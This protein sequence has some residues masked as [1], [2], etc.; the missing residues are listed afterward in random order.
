MHRSSESTP[1]GLAARAEIL[2]RNLSL[3][4]AECDVAASTLAEARRYA[5]LLKNVAGVERGRENL[6]DECRPC[7]SANGFTVAGMPDESEKQL[8][9]L[10]N[11]TEALLYR[12]DIRSGSFPFCNRAAR[13]FPALSGDVPSINTPCTGTHNEKIIDIITKDIHPEDVEDIRRLVQTALSKKSCSKFI[14]RLNYRRENK[15]HDY[16]WLNEVMTFIPGP[17]GTVSTLVG[18]AID[19]TSSKEAQAAL[20]DNERLYRTLIELCTDMIWTIGFDE[21]YEFASPAAFDMTGYTPD[22]LYLLTP[23]QLMLPESLGKFRERSRDIFAKEA[24]FPGSSEPQT[25]ELQFQRKDGSLIWGEL[26]FSAYRDDAG[27]LLG[28]CGA[29]RDVTERRMMKEELKNAHRELENRVRERTEELGFINKQ[30]K[31]EMERRMQIEHFMLHFPEQKRAAI[32]KELNDGL[33]QD[34]A[35]I[36]CL[37]DA[38]RE[39]LVKQD[40]VVVEEITGI[41]ELLSDAVKQARSMAKGLNPLHADPQGLRSSLEALSDKTSSLFNVDCIFTCSSKCGIDDPEQALNFYRIA[42]EAIHNAIRHGNA[43][44]IRILLKT[45]SRRIH[46][47]VANDGCSRS[48]GSKNPQGMGLKI[49]EYR[50]HAMKGTLKLLDRRDGGMI[51]ACTAPKR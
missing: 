22:E 10:L 3:V 47:T 24:A 44:N 50:M 38:V 20:K 1:A 15:G 29:T 19:V 26:I 21:K 43:R 6:D 16:R 4:R 39:N 41:R 17:S 37:C 7:E 11:N 2:R 35:G 18:S 46:L 25:L 28:I 13:E 27:R 42:Q 8:W 31:A 40:E 45:D 30:L 5:D 23:E 36:M 12:F 33:C 34:M 51:V 9:E 48:A 49:M 14:E 32:G